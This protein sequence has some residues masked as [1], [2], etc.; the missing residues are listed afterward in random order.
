[1]TLYFSKDLSSE[2][3]SQAFKLGESSIKKSPNNLNYND[4]DFASLYENLTTYTAE[5]GF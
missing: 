1:M 5:A 4:L 2:E 3:V